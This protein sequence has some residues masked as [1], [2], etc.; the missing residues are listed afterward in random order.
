[1]NKLITILF[2]LFLGCKKE[3]TPEKRLNKFD[4]SI[5]TNATYIILNGKAFNKPWNFDTVLIEGKH[6][7]G[8][9]T[10]FDELLLVE[11]KKNNQIVLDTFGLKNMSEIVIEL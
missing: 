4:V 3:I 9:I 2:I 10:I 7:L 6:K 5:K 11:V 1:M 8:F